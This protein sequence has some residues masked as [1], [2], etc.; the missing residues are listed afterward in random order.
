MIR[1]FVTFG[2]WNNLNT[3]IKKDKG[4]GKIKEK[5]LG[6]LKKTMKR[7]GTFLQ[8]QNYSRNDAVIISGDNYYPS[9]KKKGVEPNEVKFKEI[10]HERLVNG[11]DLLIQATAPRD[12][13]VHMIFGNHDLET[14]SGK[15]ARKQTLFFGNVDEGQDGTDLSK[16]SNAQLRQRLIDEGRLEGDCAILNIEENHFSQN[17]RLFNSIYMEDNTLIIMLDTSM[18]EI[19]SKAYLHCYKTFF[20]QF[21]RHLYIPLDFDISSANIHQ[22]QEYQQ[23]CIQLA[24][25]RAI[26]RGNIRNLVVIGHHPIVNVKT[27]NETAFITTDIPAFKSVLVNMIQQI[28]NPTERQIN[29][30]YLCAD[31]H[32]FQCGDIYIENEASVN[33]PFLI[34]QFIVGSGGTELD[35]PIPA[36]NKVKFLNRPHIF[37]KSEYSSYTLRYETPSNGFAEYKIIDGSTHVVSFIPTDKDLPS[38]DFITTDF[39]PT[40]NTFFLSQVNANNPSSFGKTTRRLATIR[41]EPSSL[42][43]SSSTFSDTDYGQGIRRHKKPRRSHKKP[44]K[45]HKKRY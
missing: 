12:V 18:Y 40:R 39:L 13:P 31:L 42:S 33:H 35:D 45:S 17:I 14:N 24:I 2:C 34:K 22:I 27:K 36:D 7:L 38:P 5:S 26:R 32:L 25:E 44:R 29:V 43:R 1:R 4:T 30:T 20:R 10:F 41:Q 28:A 6:D 23:R 21:G 19:D 3:K 16:F 15:T 11:F 9:K 37:D 8:E